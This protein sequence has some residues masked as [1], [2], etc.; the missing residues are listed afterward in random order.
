MGLSMGKPMGRHPFPITYSQKPKKGPKSG[1]RFLQSPLRLALHLR[2]AVEVPKMV[3]YDQV[4][5]KL[6]QGPTGPQHSPMTHPS[7]SG[8]S[9]SASNASSLARAASTC[10]N[11]MTS[12]SVNSWMS[13]SLTGPSRCC[14]VVMTTCSSSAPWLSTSVNKLACLLLHWLKSLRDFHHFGLDRVDLLLGGA[15][16]WKP[17]HPFDW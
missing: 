9:N 11:A 5:P 10:C 1:P 14:S 13:V 17:L 8:L 2:Q 6:G 12:Y 15:L 16:L 4:L 3:K 7:H